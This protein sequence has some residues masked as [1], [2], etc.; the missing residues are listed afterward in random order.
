MVNEPFCAISS[1]VCR[2]WDC[3]LPITSVGFQLIGHNG[4]GRPGSVVVDIW[5]ILCVSNL[6][7]GALR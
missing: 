6:N 2:G 4:I 3:S 5:A 7:Y 1:G